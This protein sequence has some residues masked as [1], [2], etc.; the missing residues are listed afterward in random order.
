MTGSTWMFG[1]RERERITLEQCGTRSQLL[2]VQALEAIGVDVEL[3]EPS[4][5]LTRSLMIRANGLTTEILP[6][7]RVRVLGE[8][9][10]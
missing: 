2:T 9:L 8:T 10:A 1:A 4:D 6:W 7:G 3:V 5:R